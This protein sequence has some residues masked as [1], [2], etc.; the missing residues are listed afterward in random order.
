M[1]LN[2][3]TVNFE[4]IDSKT[5]L[6]DWVWLVGQ[7]KLPILLLASG[8]AFLQDINS[9]KVYFLDTGFGQVEEAA[10]SAQ[11]LQEL[12]SN[13]DFVVDYFSVN[14]VGDLIQNGLLLDVGQ[15]YSMDIPPVL[16]GEPSTGNVSPTDIEVHFSIA[17]QI[18]RQLKDLPEGTKITGFNVIDGQVELS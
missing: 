8:D 10:E 17:G 12:L 9:G 3:L 7:A 4:H 6:E 18:H 15:I 5:L 2:D 11:E 14:L 16:G 1:T 13:K